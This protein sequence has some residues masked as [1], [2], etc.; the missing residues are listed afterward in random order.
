MEK[1]YFSTG[2]LV[3]HPTTTKKIPPRRPVAGVLVRRAVGV[4]GIKFKLSYYRRS[5]CTSLRNGKHFW[6]LKTRKYTRRTTVGDA[7]TRTNRRHARRNGTN[8][9]PNTTSAR[10]CGGDSN[11]K[12]NTWGSYVLSRRLVVLVCFFFFFHF[13]RHLSRA[14]QGTKTRALLLHAYI[15]LLTS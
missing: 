3:E 10:P 13:A 5:R 6:T 15:L 2:V 1:R 4:L 7:T 9:E 11:S 12:N 14:A 8:C